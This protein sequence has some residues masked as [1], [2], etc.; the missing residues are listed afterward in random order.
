VNSTSALGRIARLP[1][2]FL[3]PELVVPVLAGPLRGK[4]W[5]VGSSVHRCWLGLYEYDKLRHVSSEIRAN[6]IF[7]DVGA[8]VG[9]YS[10]LASR[11]VGAGHVFAFEPVPRNIFY[12]K[13]HLALNH[14][15]NTQVFELAVADRDD[16]LRFQIEDTGLMGHLSTEGGFWVSAATLDSLV[17]DGKIQPPNYIKMDIEGS[18]LLALR[19]ASE[20]IQRHRPVIFLATHGREVHDACCRLLESWRYECR[21][22]G[23]SMSEDRGEVV[24]RPRLEN[25]F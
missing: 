6:T 9:L 2:S 11:L 10:L 12:L 16:T 7:Y 23:R 15:T 18:E 22:L 1:L 25:E 20:C 19:G 4:K 5:I 8:N 13:R 21:F 14:I 24:A 17:D 3:R